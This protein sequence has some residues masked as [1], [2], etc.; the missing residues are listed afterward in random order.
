MLGSGCT[1]TEALKNLVLGGIAGFTVVDN[2]IVQASDLGANF[3][4]ETPSLGKARAAAVTELLAELNEGVAS[5]YV[6]E[7][8]TH[9][10]E[11]NPAFFLDFQLVLATQVLSTHENIGS[12]TPLTSKVSH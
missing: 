12:G 2:A 5:S 7:A 11:N 10:I 3:L 4:L 8:P 6:E 1:S 9:V